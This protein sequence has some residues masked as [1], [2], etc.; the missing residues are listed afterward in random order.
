[1][2]YYCC[3]PNYPEMH[4]YGFKRRIRSRFFWIF[5]DDVEPVDFSFY[6]QTAD[7]FVGLDHP[8]EPIDSKEPID[9]EKP[10][11][12]KEPIASEEPTGEWNMWNNSINFFNILVDIISTE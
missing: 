10:M 7:A 12:P 3:L 1:M 8:E 4:C 11:D 2:E 6:S 5:E 9:S